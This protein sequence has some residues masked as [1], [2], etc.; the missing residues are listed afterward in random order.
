MVRRRS[1][2]AKAGTRFAAIIAA[3]FSAS[4]RLGAAPVDSGVDLSSSVLA[5]SC[6]ACHGTAGRAWRGGAVPPLAGLPR[7]Y[8]LKQM[9]GYR[10][11]TGNGTVMPQIAKGYADD[12]IETLADYFATRAASP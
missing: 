8:F 2:R 5:A 10:D 6:T 7:E 11:G 9:R 4:I 12:Q 3:L 1:I